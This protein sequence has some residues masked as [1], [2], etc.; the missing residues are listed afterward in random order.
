MNDNYSRT[1]IVLHWLIALLIFGAFPLGLYMA[2][3]QLSPLKL[4][5]FS[6]HKWAGICVLLLV[7]LRLVW[8]K[9]HRPPPLLAGMPRWQEIAAHAVHHALYLMMV[10]VPLS[11]WLMSSALGFPVVLFGVLPLPDLI[12]KDLALGKAL[13]EVHEFLNYAMLALVLAHI[14][15]A[16]K[17]HVVDRDRTLVRMLPLLDKEKS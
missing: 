7:V 8:R 4:R 2:D 3:L 1:A 13:E 10:I 16:I 15:G 11:G 14:A 17:H 5:L 6:Y 9:L 12:G